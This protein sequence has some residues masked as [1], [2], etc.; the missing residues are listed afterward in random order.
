ML[1][2][3]PKEI[4]AEE[5]RVGLTPGSV[6]QLRHHGHEVVVETNAGHAIGLDDDD[7]RAVGGEVVDSAA[8][9]FAR[10]EMIVKVKEPQPVKCGMLREGFIGLSSPRNRI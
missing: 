9:I 3:V 10:A 6:R 5:H 1:I 8:E 4:K 7:Y 2:G